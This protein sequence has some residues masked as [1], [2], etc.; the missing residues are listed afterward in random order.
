[1]RR[2]E[3]ILEHFSCKKYASYKI[4]LS[5]EENNLSFFKKA[6]YVILSFKN[7]VM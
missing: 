6:I 1:M 3:R 5:K 4:N 7:N 2:E